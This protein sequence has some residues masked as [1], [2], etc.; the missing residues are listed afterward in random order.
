MIWPRSM[1]VEGVSEKNLPAKATGTLPHTRARF[2]V[3]QL[4]EVVNL[5]CQCGGGDPSERCSACLV[6]HHLMG[7]VF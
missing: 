3:A 7:G 1:Y 2:S 5:T 4:R 6:W